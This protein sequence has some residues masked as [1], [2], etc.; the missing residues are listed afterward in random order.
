MIALRYSTGIARPDAVPALSEEIVSYVRL[1]SSKTR[2]ITP[3]L[4]VY[5]DTSEDQA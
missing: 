4:R 2:T 3:Y 1:I 5:G